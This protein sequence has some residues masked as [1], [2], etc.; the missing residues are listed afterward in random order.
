MF[1]FIVIYIA[2]LVVFDNI[3]VVKFIGFNRVK[4]A[5]S[6]GGAIGEYPIPLLSSK[7]VLLDCQMFVLSHTVPKGLCN[8]GG[9]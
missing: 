9:L 4:A 2:V 6:G 7:V 1:G 5:Q 3:L 8:V